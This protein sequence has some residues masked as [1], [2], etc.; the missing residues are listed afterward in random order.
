MIKT[1]AIAQ[2][3]FDERANASRVAQA[4][5]QVAEAELRQARIDLDHAFVKAPI[6]GSVSRAEITLGNRVQAG[7]SAPVLCSI[8]SRNDIYV[9]F[10]VDEQSYLQ[11]IRSKAG[12]RG[13]EEQIQ[14][15]LTVQGDDKRPYKGT[16]YS[17]DNHIDSASGTIRARAKFDN[18]D[19]RLVPGMFAKVRLASSGE[20]D[21]L[22]VPEQAVGS[23]QSKKFVYLV[24][25]DGK[26]VYREVGLGQQSQGHRIVVA[27]LERGDRV[28]VDGLQ[29]VKPGEA[30]QAKPVALKYDGKQ[31]A[32]D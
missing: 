6:G 32:A 17:F 13:K 28:I 5:I 15:E 30:V 22:L 14:V 8:V 31:V 19:G 23:D 11:N 24:G 25:A 7:A 12:T 21:V 10:E 27:G 20:K 2:R 9:D 18:K 26:V 4:A 3:V 1:Q 16:V 29:H